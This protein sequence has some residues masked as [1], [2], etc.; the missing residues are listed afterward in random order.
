MLFYLFFSFLGVG[1]FGWLGVVN[2]RK[3]IRVIIKYII[4]IDKK[5]KNIFVKFIMILNGYK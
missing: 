2:F 5:I 1:F 4:D 3:E